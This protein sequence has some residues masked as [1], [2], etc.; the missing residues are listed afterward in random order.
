MYLNVNQVRQDF[1]ILSRKV[2]G[3][4][5]IYFDNAATTQ[6]PQCV[7]DA[8]N[9]YYQ[10]YNS[11]VHRGAHQLAHEATEAFENARKSIAQF[12]NADD[13][14]QI[15]FTRGTTESVNLVAYSFGINKLKK[16]DEVITF[17]S[18]HHSNFVPWQQACLKTGAKFTVIGLNAD[19]ELD[20]AAFK[21]ALNPKVKLVAVNHTSNALGNRNNIEQIINMSKQ[22]GSLVFLDAAQ[23]VCHENV[24]VNVLDVDFMAF[25]AHKMLGPTG[26]GVLYA[27][28]ECLAQMEPFQYGGEMIEEVSVLKTTFNQAPYKF[29]A[30]T[31]NICGAIATA[32]AIQYIGK[33]GLQNIAAYEH[34]LLEYA[35]EQMQTHI[36]GLKIYGSPNKAAIISFNIDKIHPF[37]IGLLLN[38]NGVAMRTGHHCCQPLMSYFNLEGT[39]R[40]SFAF[41]N[42]KAEIDY[43]V[44]SLVKALKMLKA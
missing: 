9:T 7:I 5:L 32:S 34:E 27:K 36:E 41:Y 31:P 1:P 28:A 20:L 15:I 39:C 37:D 25:S 2:N 24:D 22:N 38:Q 18:E 40:A 12:V 4:T 43:F 14:K 30:G 35:T 11:N 13:A 42:T 6:K 16:D 10:E 17:I 8:I 23:A 26:F 19:E 33:L 29:E 44:N 3:K 21:N